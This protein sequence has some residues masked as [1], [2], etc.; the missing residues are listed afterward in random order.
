MKTEHRTTEG[1]A[2]W[3]VAK[4][5][6]IC[7]VGATGEKLGKRKRAIS[8]HQ[9]SVDLRFDLFCFV[10]KWSHCVTQAGL[11]LVIF[12]PLECCG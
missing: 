8:P 10:D 1:D 4:G 2:S 12:L 6:R 3:S 7:C 5:N 9:A 11:E